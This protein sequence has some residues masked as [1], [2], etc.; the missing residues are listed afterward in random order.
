MG[1]FPTPNLSIAAFLHSI[2]YRGKDDPVVEC[3]IQYC[4]HVTALNLFEF[5]LSD[6]EL[7]IVNELRESL[8]TIDRA[9]TKFESKEKPEKF[10]FQLPLPRCQICEQ[11]YGGV[12]K[13]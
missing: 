10:S 1:S 9:L 8:P 2:G 3:Y 12:E 5:G 6:L 11:E 13:R 7:S 4:K